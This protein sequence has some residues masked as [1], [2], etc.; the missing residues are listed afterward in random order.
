MVSTVTTVLH[1][2]IAYSRNLY[3]KFVYNYNLN[4]TV[5]STLHESLNEDSV[6]QKTPYKVSEFGRR[7]TM[8][9]D[10]E[11]CRALKHLENS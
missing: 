6:S 2:V 8:F 10:V 5:S 9:K 4:L 7:A 3:N 11:M 1:C